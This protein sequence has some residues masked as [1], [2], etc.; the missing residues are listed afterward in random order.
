MVEAERGHSCL[1]GVAQHVRDRSDIVR[2]PVLI[3]RIY[4]LTPLISSKE[5]KFPPASALP[6]VNVW[7]PS[8]RT[9]LTIREGGA[10]ASTELE[11]DVRTAANK[12]CQEGFFSL[13][14]PGWPES[15]ASSILFVRPHRPNG[16]D[17]IGSSRVHTLLI[18]TRFLDGIFEAARSQ[19]SNNI[20]LQLFQAF[21]KHSLTRVAAGWSHEIIVHCCLCSKKK[22]FQIFQ[23]DGTL[24]TISPST[25]LLP[26]TFSGLRGVEP[27]TPFYWIPSAINLP[28]VDSVLGDS[29]G[30]IY[31]VHATI[32]IDHSSPLEGLKLV[33][34]TVGGSLRT[35]GVWH[36]LIASDNKSTAKAHVTK[37]SNELKDKLFGSQK[38]CMKV[39]GC[40]ITPSSPQL[41]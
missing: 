37:Y 7:G 33:W 9:V 1:L 15:L 17:D 18:P 31:A 41:E 34:N 5:L 27:D 11:K 13:S 20:S 39:W 29:Q 30:N 10:P 2:R 26:G 24:D 16:F 28:G 21:S 4:F 35:K 38:V 14:K 3:N 8:I 40:V 36:F 12:I 6:I 32:A 23:A 19:A 25:I 22:P